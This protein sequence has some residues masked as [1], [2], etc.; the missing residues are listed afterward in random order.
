[1]NPADQVV[2]NALQSHES[3]QVQVGLGISEHQMIS[4]RQNAIQEF[5]LDAAP[6]FALDIDGD[7]FGFFADNDEDIFGNYGAGSEYHGLLG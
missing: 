7:V 3:D 2:I 1:M 4:G 6:D 5:S